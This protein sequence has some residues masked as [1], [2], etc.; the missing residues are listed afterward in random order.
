MLL[1]PPFLPAGNTHRQYTD[2]D[3]DD[4]M[5]GGSVGSG[6]F[7]VST[8]WV[9][10]R[11]LHLEAPHAR[12]PVRAIADGEVIYVRQN[13]YV[14]DKNNVRQKIQYNG[15]AYSTGCVVIRHTT[16]I[17]A[18]GDKPTRI[19]FYSITQHLCDIEQR[20]QV[21]HKLHRKDPLGKAGY[22]RDQEA[23][24]HFEIIAGDSDAQCMIPRLNTADRRL[25]LEQ[26]GRTDAV[27][28]TIY[29]YVKAGTVAHIK[30]AMKGGTPTTE[31]YLIGIAY[32][33][34]QGQ[35]GDATLTTYRLDG[36][37]VGTQHEAEGEYQ[38]YKRAQ[39]THCPSAAYELLR[40]GRV[41]GPD[42]LQ[43]ADTPHWRQV[44]LPTGAAY[45]NLAPAAISKF[46]DADFPD[47]TGWT[48]VGDDMDDHDSRCNSAIIHTML[49]PE[50]GENTEDRRSK[51][52]CIHEMKK[53][54]QYRGP[55]LSGN[56]LGCC[57]GRGM[58]K[59]EIM[60]IAPHRR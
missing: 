60:Q 40:F 22:I 2:E 18:Q 16:E 59:Y 54:A 34:G 43:P 29:F 44:A 45:L 36:S 38:L 37:I 4:A 14:L 7:P 27:F 26:N 8:A 23:R 3:I 21:G 41:L 55:K 11:G 1:S 42:Q 20:L 13:S 52:L 28:G 32:G 31:D 6:A 46:S 25:V 19:T 47:W 9:W 58:R 48:L 15:S 51:N 35:G 57:F 12:E 50:Y 33:T 30:P 10:H 53:I 5:F 56:V 17:G 24:I 49:K 39:D